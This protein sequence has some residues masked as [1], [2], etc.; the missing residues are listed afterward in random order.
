MKIYVLYTWIYLHMDLG[1]VK[2]Q[3]F[4]VSEVTSGYTLDLQY[5]DGSK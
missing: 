4:G 2:K 3:Q 5:Y 1:P